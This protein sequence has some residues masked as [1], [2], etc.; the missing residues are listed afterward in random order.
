[1]TMIA[2]SEDESA[3]E[4][5]DTMILSIGEESYISALLLEG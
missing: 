5:L 4:L 2:T 1:M 3:A